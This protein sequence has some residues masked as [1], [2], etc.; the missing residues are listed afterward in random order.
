M[1]YSYNSRSL[2]TN[3]THTKLMTW[4]INYWPNEERRYPGSTKSS[5]RCRYTS[6]VCAGSSYYLF[7]YWNNWRRY[8]TRWHHRF[9]G[10]TWS[11]ID[12]TVFICCTHRAP[13]DPTITQQWSRPTP[14]SPST[15][16]RKLGVSEE[17]DSEP[18]K[19]S[20][21]LLASHAHVNSHSAA[22]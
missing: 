5:V 12:T 15:A 21:P 14:R 1:G 2:I 10:I 22:S 6:Q 13:F 16:T 4:S 17:G 20:D 7:W 9:Q 8:K 11:G 3:Y 19:D 18:Q